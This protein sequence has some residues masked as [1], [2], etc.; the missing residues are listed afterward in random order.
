MGDDARV[1]SLLAVD[2]PLTQGEL[3][4]RLGLPVRSVQASLQA[5]RCKGEPICTG[6]AGCW[7]ARTAEELAVS[8]R[9]LRH[10]LAEQY[11]TLK[12]QQQAE[13]RMRAAEKGELTLWAA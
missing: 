5:L 3:A 1:L 9:R 2:G 10:R 6:A 8:N 7:L 12:A 11:R 13:R 4:R